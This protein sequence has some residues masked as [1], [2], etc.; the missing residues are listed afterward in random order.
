MSGTEDLGRSSGK[1][2]LIADVGDQEPDIRGAGATG[3]G[4]QRDKEPARRVVVERRIEMP[5]PSP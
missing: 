1:S 5:G 2:A 3:V 4:P